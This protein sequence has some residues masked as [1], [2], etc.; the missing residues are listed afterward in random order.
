VRKVRRLLPFA[1]LIFVFA[2]CGGSSSSLPYDKV[3]FKAADA[4]RAFAA[5]RVYLA[6]KSHGP[7]GSTLGDT[8]DVIEVDVFGDPAALSREG[9]H[10]L[11]H[12]PDCTVAGHLA[13]RW[14]GN[15]RAILNCDLVR[16]DAPWVA[17]MDRA[18]AALG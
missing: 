8:H 5:Q 10:D 18:L 6:L 14:R 1:I 7:S 2:G 11:A 17:R 3:S 16:N 4:R 12:G 13:L 15:V 9:F